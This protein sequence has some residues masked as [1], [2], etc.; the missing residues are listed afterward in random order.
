MDFAYGRRGLAGPDRFLERVLEAVPGLLSWSLILGMAALSAARPL[1]AA[2]FVIAFLLYWLLRLLYMNIFLVISYVRLAVEKG[3]AWDQLLRDIDRGDAVS[4]QATPG[5]RQ[6]LVRLIRDRQLRDM[7][8][9]GERPPSSRDIHHLV[10]Y[11]VVRE[12]RD[13]LEPGIRRIAEGDFSPKRVLVVI[14]VE[15][16]APERV[17]RDAEALAALYRGRFLDLLVVVH[18]QDLPGEAR[19]KGANATYAAK[20]AAQR[21]RQ[22]G[23]PFENV[24][25]SCF[26]ADTVPAEDYFS[27]LTYHFLITP[28]RTRASFQPVPVYHNNFWQVPAFARV[29]DV[30]TSF[31]QLIEATDPNKLVTFSSHSMSFKALVEV[32]YWPVDMISDDSAIFWKAFLH[33]D[34]R[35]RSVP[36][37]TTVS[38]D[39]AAGAGMW[40]TLRSIYRQKRRWAWGVENFPIVMRA[41]LRSRRIPLKARAAYGFKL[42]DGFVAW[43]TWS[44]LL[45]FVSWLPGVFAGDAFATST[46]Y[47]TEPRIQA[48]IFGLASLAVLVCMFLGVALLPRRAGRT[49]LLEAVRHLIEWLLIPVIVLFLSA[50]PALDAQT[51]LMFGRYLEFQPTQKFRKTP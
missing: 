1:L 32:G 42:L 44:F 45:T 21:L 40:A 26:D 29:I 22:E 15:E 27:C 5:V 4:P 23:I 8:R 17:R 50:L 48:T 16:T 3:S 19:V 24:L 11:P 14:A 51:R 18:P 34:G 43:A 10:V 46:V 25:V 37:Y 28:D 6:R 35:Y 38:M 47:Y 7:K 13:I 41:F 36:M 20:Q 30:G 31:F 9:S 33:Y 39:I 12:G 2:L 49:S